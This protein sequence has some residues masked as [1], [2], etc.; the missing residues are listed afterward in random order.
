MTCVQQANAR[1]E[2]RQIL[3]GIGSSFREIATT[4]STAG[5]TYS[6][7]STP[8]Q[9]PKAKR[10]DTQIQSPKAEKKEKPPINKES[11]FVEP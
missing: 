8:I 1:E 11:K 6:S 4:S 5:G 2:W 3:R 10:S 9:S 7:R